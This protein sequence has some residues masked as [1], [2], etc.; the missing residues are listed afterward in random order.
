M[1]SFRYN[2]IDS[3]Q[4][5]IEQLA[6]LDDDTTWS[7]LE[8]GGQV[9]RDAQSAYLEA[10]HKITG[11]LAAS[12]KLTRKVSGGELIARIEPKGKHPGSSTGKRM[13]KEG[14]KRRSSG[15]YS[16]SNAEIAYILEYGSPRIPAT[17]WMET[18][19]EGAEEEMAAAME[20]AWDD[21]LTSLGL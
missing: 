6:Q 17:H 1:A 15:S 3:L 9:L 20:S 13:K 7:I 12:I 19:N 14:G 8:A 2:G 16:G 4:A 5:S 10:Y 11:A 21:Y 18:A